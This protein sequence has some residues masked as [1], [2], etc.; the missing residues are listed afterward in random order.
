MS[1]HQWTQA[2]T[3][4]V[5]QFDYGNDEH[6]YVYVAHLEKRKYDLIMAQDAIDDMMQP[7]EWEREEWQRMENELL[8]VEEQLLQ[9]YPLF[10]SHL[11]TPISRFTHS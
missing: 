5:E 6:V 10:P 2:D 8:V 4:F 9:V 3:D 7:S 11:T 1:I